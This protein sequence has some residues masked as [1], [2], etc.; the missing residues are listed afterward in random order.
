M[1]VSVVEGPLV[2]I[3]PLGERK[4]KHNECLPVKVIR[5]CLLLQ[6][7]LEEY[8][9]MKTTSVFGMQVVFSIHGH[10]H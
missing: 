1:C 7:F 8:T 6:Q 5:V 9:T 2:V 4:E 3:I 10:T